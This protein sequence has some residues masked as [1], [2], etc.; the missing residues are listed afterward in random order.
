MPACDYMF[1]ESPEV[2]RRLCLL[3]GTSRLFAETL[4]H[5]PDELLS[6]G[7]ADGLALRPPDEL[8]ARATAALTWR[9]TAVDRQRGLYRY[10]QREELHIAARDVL[11]LDGEEDAVALTGDSFGAVARGQKYSNIR[12]VPPDAAAQFQSAHSAWHDHI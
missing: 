11:G 4:E 8:A 7:D 9:R 1:R 10:R 6:L 12:I 5:N 2:A 3:L